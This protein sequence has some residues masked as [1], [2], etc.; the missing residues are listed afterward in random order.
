MCRH[1]L[2]LQRMLLWPVERHSHPRVSAKLL[3]SLYLETYEWT[4]VMP[5]MQASTLMKK[6]LSKEGKSSLK[7]SWLSKQA[8]SKKTLRQRGSNWERFFIPYRCIQ[9]FSMICTI[10]NDNYCIIIPHFFFNLKDFY[11]HSNWVELGNKVPYANLIKSDT[12]IGNIAGKDW[13]FDDWVCVGNE[14]C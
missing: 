7:E 3:H 8:T 14:Q 10:T 12:S 13:S 4:F 5:L 6:C 1:S 2:S 9:L 11:S